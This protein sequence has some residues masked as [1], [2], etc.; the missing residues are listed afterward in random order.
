MFEKNIIVNHITNLRGLTSKGTIACDKRGAEKVHPEI[1]FVMDRLTN[2]YNSMVGSEIPFN[3]LGEGNYVVLLLQEHT[4]QPAVSN[5]LMEESPKANTRCVRSEFEKSR[6][7][8]TLGIRRIHSTT[9][10]C[11][12]GSSLTI[13]R[14]SWLSGQEQDEK[15]LTLKNDLSLTGKAKNLSEIMSDPDFLIASWVRIWSNRHNLTYTLG[16]TLDVIDINWFVETAS[17]MR[18]GA[19]RFCSSKRVYKSKPNS[20]FSH[21]IIPFSKDIIVQEGMR[22]LLEIIFEPVFSEHSY[23]FRPNKEWHAALKDI[24]RDCSSISWYIKGNVEQQFPS[25]NHKILGEILIEHIQDQAFIDLIYKYLRSTYEKTPGSK[26]P[27]Q[28]GVLQC[29][30]IYPMLSNIYMIPF[31]R[32][33]GKYLI[34]KYILEENRKENPEYL[35]LLRRYKKEGRQP[36]F[37]RVEPGL[38]ADPNW[39]RLY[40]FRYAGDFIIGVDGHRKD[41]VDIKEEI[42]NFLMEKLGLTLNDDKTKIT[43]SEDESARFLGYR[44][45]KSKIDKNLIKRNASGTITKGPSRVILGAPIDDIIKKLL[46]EG[47]VKNSSEQK[48]LPTRNGKFVNLQLESIIDHYKAVEVGILNYYFLASN[49]GRLSA[50]IHHLLKYSCALTIASKK[51]LK[52]LRGVFNKY[53]KDLSVIRTNGKIVTYPAPKYA[54][55][56]TDFTKVEKYDENFIEKLSSGISRGRKDP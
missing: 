56:K 49:Y 18:N 27:M 34:P 22:Y 52:T 23:R 54:R 11:G 46:I 47:Y 31:D 6:K 36:D 17:G 4:S 10:I 8:K 41:C 9:V 7:V 20:K 33:V 30:I 48:Y 24:R 40:Y 38:S 12:K 55:T 15:L 32:W 1:Q 43:N 19:F 13:S 44:I 25:I 3:V 42:R 16:D 39:K 21:S 26:L 50:R 37:K 28:I 51:K 29:D 35:K 5:G 53:G 45:H 2:L 14:N